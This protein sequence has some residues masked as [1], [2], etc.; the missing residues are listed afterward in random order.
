MTILD[1]SM[2]RALLICLIYFGFNPHFAV[3]DSIEENLKKCLTGKYTATC[4]QNL[5]TSEQKVQV[6]NAQRAENLR[7]CL[8]GKYQFT[9]NVDALT[10]NQKQQVATARREVAKRSTTLRGDSLY[11]PA[12]TQ[13]GSDSVNSGYIGAHS[14]S[15]IMNMGGGDMMNLTTGEYIMDMGGGDMMN[16]TTGDYIMD[17]GG[18]DKM[19]LGTGDY[20]MNMGGGDMMNLGT[21]DY[22]MNMGGGDVLNLGTGEYITNF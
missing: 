19:N 9:C 21:G 16:L 15:Y 5:L 6:A 2:K 8:T 1:E 12:E 14:S 17:M 22:L 13:R 4:K 3:A 7:K 10:D 11:A 20:I 18:G